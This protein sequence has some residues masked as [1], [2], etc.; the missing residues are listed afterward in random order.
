MRPTAPPLPEG[1]FSIILADPPWEF[2][3]RS[4]LGR[5]RS[6]RYRVMRTE[7]IA[8]LPVERLATKDC[9]LFLWA[10]NPNTPDAFEIMRAWGFSYSGVFQTWIKLQEN[11]DAW[12]FGMVYGSRQN[13]ERISLGRR[14]KP[15]RL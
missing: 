15:K 1:Q 6:P 13:P 11:G 14:G 9:W 2:R 8:A 5:G 12:H 3:T 10:T 7:A 4:A